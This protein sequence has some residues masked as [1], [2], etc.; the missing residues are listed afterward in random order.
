VTLAY[1]ATAVGSSL[2][3][4]ALAVGF[5]RFLVAFTKA[6]GHHLPTDLYLSTKQR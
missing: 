5:V 4:L 2:L 6:A 1:L 3:G